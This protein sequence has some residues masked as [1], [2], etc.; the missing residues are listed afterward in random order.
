[1]NKIEAFEWIDTQHDR[2]VETVLAWSNINSG[3]FNVEGVREMRKTL[4][5]AL[6]PL[7]GEAEVLEV[8]PLQSVSKTGELEEIPL[9]EVLRIRKRPNAPIK[10]ALSGHMD[11]VFPKGSHFQ[12][13]KWLDD[14]TINGPGVTDLKGGLVC[15]MVALEA[16]EKS[17]LAEKI[18]WEIVLNPDEEIGSQ[19]SNPFLVEAAKRNHVGLIYEPSLADGTMVGAR[20][21]SGN[22]VIVVKGRA[23]HA[24]REIEK[25]RNAIVL[26]A[27]MIAELNALNGKREGVTLNAGKIEGG[28]PTNIVPDTAILRFNVR[29]PEMQD[30]QWLQDEFD[31][32][33]AR[34]NEREGYEV[35]LHGAFTRPPK[36]LS[37]DNKR[38]LEL[39]R[40]CGAEL[41]QE[42]K[43]QPTGGC[44]DGNNMAAAG[45]PN[46]D[47]LGVRG[48]RIHSD[49][50]FLLVDSLTERAK[51][52]A[53]IL[54]KLAEE[55]WN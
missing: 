13:P 4:E 10:V 14:N 53:A 34:Y 35:S 49:E 17:P 24:G 16:L 44:C 29:M 48:G 39:V 30:K 21:G 51:L 40:D 2:M 45:L 46:V 32:M 28:G 23:A 7:G 42:I 25:G 15:M 37:D 55:G 54:F 18:G 9:A 41:G 12:E 52:S 19:G 26:L 5:K 22:F 11:T 1:M 38:L 47:T 27:E 3:S 36:T 43:W 8:S 20:K 33:L 50:E 31:Q 6:A